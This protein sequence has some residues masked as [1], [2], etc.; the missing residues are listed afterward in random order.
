MLLTLFGMTP[1]LV[2]LAALHAGGTLLYIALVS[3]ILFNAPRIFG[4]N[5]KDIVL[6]PIA[7]LLLFV[8]SAALTGSLILGR[9]ILWYLDGKKKEAVALFMA[10]LGFLFLFT[11]VAFIALIVLTR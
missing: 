2:K 10:T 7:M 4:G 5:G 11:L 6:I 8:F 3:S 1:S 9:P